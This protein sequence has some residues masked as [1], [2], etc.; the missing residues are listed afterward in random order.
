VSTDQPHAPGAH[1]DLD[2]LADLQEGLLPP[3]PAA[4]ISDH[5]D[6]CEACRADFAA[7]GQISSRL[8]GAAEVGAF[9]DELARRLDQTLGEQPRTASLTITPLAAARR[10][11]LYR[12]NRVLQA[13]A[14][15]VLVLAAGAIGVAAYQGSG[16]HGTAADSAAAGGSPQEFSEAS[17][18]V[19]STGT[20]YNQDTVVA[21]VPRLLTTHSPKAVA[22]P[23]ASDSPTRAADQATSGANRLSD[24]A[25]LAACVGALADDEDTPV[26]ERAT[27]LVVDVAK[28]DHKPATVIIL[29]APDRVDRLDVFVVA[30]TCGLA[31]AALLHY[32]RVPRP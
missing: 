16:D 10:N 3:S 29:P 12:D 30:P 25:A 13:A 14:A 21:A 1:P 26:I 2:H 24:P 28:Y 9:P 4:A 15:A 8:A 20:D 19:L 5:L 18:A 6:E 17:G 27:P 11:R 7:L 31:D 32:A 22:A 23:E